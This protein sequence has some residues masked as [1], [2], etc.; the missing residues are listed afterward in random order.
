MNLACRSVAGAERAAILERAADLYERDREALMALISREGGRTIPAALSEIR[1]A[2]D[3]LRYYAAR[4]RADFA[5]PLPLPGPTGER[6]RLVLH[7]RGVFACISPW[8]FP[9]AIFTGQVAAVS[10]GLW[11]GMAVL[12]L[13]YP[14]DSAAEADANFVL[15]GNGGIVEVQGTAEKDPFSEAQFLELMT[16]AKKGVGELTRLQRLAIGKP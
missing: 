9:L 1:E 10:C 4:A 15:T 13:D 14:E 6:N 5:E 2:A 12:D 16:L 3:Y 11:E 7:G 8:N